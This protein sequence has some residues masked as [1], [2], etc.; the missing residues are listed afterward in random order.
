LTEFKID[1]SVVLPA[2]NEEYLLKSTTDSV[3]NYLRSITDD[4]EVIIVENGSTDRTLEIA[5]QLSA[6]VSNVVITHLDRADYGAAL[7]EGFRRAQGTFVVN[8][9]VDYFDFGFLENGLSLAKE[10]GAAVVV[11][12]KRAEGSDDQRTLLR[13]VL[14]A[15]FTA[16]LVRGFGMPVTDAHG[17]KILRREELLPLVEA[18]QMTESLFDV[19][20]VIRAARA[21][22]I[23]RELPVVVKELRPPRSSVARR[24]LEVLGGLLRLHRALRTTVG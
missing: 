17:M 18:C 6:N 19:E 15:G 2:H 13:R 22:L 11:A 1:L 4:F 14:T 7:V 12:S 24:I 16:I 10:S 20:L 3:C 5:Q 8:F 9:D 21:G 23:S